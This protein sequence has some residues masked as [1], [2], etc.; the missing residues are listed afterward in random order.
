MAHIPLRGEVVENVT[1]ILHSC[2]SDEAREEVK[3]TI[4]GL[5]K[6][7]GD[8]TKW[9]TLT[10]IINVE[11]LVMVRPNLN[12]LTL[13][14]QN[15]PARWSIAVSKVPPPTTVHCTHICTRRVTSDSMQTVRALEARTTNPPGLD[16]A[17]EKA[18][19]MVNTV[20][21]KLNDLE[22]IVGTQRRQRICST[23]SNAG[24]AQGCK[25]NG[26]AKQYLKKV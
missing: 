21:S 14:V 7:E 24:G 16:S 19:N 5:L 20:Q 8:R 11:R 4:G 25:R 10:D 15:P 17:L 13:R 2:A 26:R 23:V 1:P 3:N 6:S 22:C 18:D 12:V 9:A